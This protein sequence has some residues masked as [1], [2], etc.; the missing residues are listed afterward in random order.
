MRNTVRPCVPLVGKKVLLVGQ[1]FAI[2]R[3]IL[4]LRHVFIYVSGRNG[5]YTEVYG[6]LEKGKK[7]FVFQK[8]LPHKNMSEFASR[9]FFGIF[10]CSYHY[11]L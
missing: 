10:L 5:Y 8:K 6:V 11:F 2:P 1:Y 9:Y 3:L 4:L 7:R